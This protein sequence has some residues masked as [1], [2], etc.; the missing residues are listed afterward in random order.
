MKFYVCIKQVPDVDAPIQIKDGKLIQDT[1][2]MVLNAYDASAVE[3]ALVLKEEHGGEVEVVLVGPDKAKETI[4]KALAM[5]ADKATHI[6][7]S[8]DEDYDSATYAN[9]LATFFSDKEY[10]VI[11]CGKQSQDTDAGLAG[12]MLG[13]HLDLPYATN[14]V[15]L[16]AEEG[17]LVVKRQGDAGQEIIGLPTPCL[18][19]CSNDMNEPRIPSLKGIMQSKRKPVEDVAL[20][21]LDIDES[22]LQ[23]KTKVTGHMEKP[24]REPGQ[25]FEGEPE[26]L[27][28]K[29]ATLLDEEENV[30]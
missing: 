28:Q 5:G 29:V 3:E 12:S 10:D 11:S 30:I 13:E 7:T 17:T 6:A 4:R 25:K 18:V 20:S 9:I 15:G 24:E 26:E 22:S 27:A 19:T 2:R 1:D 21:D 14:A 16:E 8:G 23:P